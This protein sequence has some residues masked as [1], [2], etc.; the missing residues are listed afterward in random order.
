MQNMYENSCLYANSLTRLDSLEVSCIATPFELL[1]T[2]FHNGDMREEG[3]PYRAHMAR[4]A[5]SFSALVE[6]K[7]AK[8]L[9]GLLQAVYAVIYL[10]DVDET[11]K[12]RNAV[13]PWR[14]ALESMIES[15]HMIVP[16]QKSLDIFSADYAGRMQSLLARIGPTEH[17]LGLIVNIVKSLDIN[18]NSNSVRS[19]AGEEKTIERVMK[20]KDYERHIPELSE[21]IIVNPYGGLIEHKR[22][23][24][25]TSMTLDNLHRAVDVY[26]R[27]LLQRKSN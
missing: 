16:V 14:S 20:L 26:E 22:L 15:P 21:Q 5:Q 2:E 11:L 7:A 8:E 23:A 12:K 4:M 6:D 17:E 9:P 27:Q 25:L 24:S 18:D 3:V 13:V 19:W 10:H 1:A